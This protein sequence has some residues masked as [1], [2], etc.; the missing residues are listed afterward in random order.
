MPSMSLVH[1]GEKQAKNSKKS[2]GKGVS[3]EVYLGGC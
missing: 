2:T 3:F 1:C